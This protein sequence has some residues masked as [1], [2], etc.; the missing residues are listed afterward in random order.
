MSGMLSPSSGTPY[1][2]ARVCRIWRS[3]RAS[4]YRHR[5]PASARQGPGPAGPMPEAA[6]L[7]RIRDDF[8]DSPFHGE[9]HR[10]VRARLRIGSIRTFWLKVPF[11]T[12]PAVC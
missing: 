3:A 1:G 5:H 8:S 7:E 12:H 6:P 10:K 9:G 2:L 11:K 4:I